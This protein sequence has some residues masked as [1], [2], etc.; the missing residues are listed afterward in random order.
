MRNAKCGRRPFVHASGERGVALIMAVL[1]LLILTF[2]GLAL[3]NVG[4]VDM[5]LTGND[6]ASTEALYIADAGIAHAKEI[7]VTRGST[8]F[9]QY[10]TAGNGTGCDGDELSDDALSTAPHPQFSLS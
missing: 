9:D 3:T 2:L 5:R 1:A 7:V 6:H 10:L 4:T 8:D